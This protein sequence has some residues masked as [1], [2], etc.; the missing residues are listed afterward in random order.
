MQ[1]SM[2]PELATRRH[3]I[4]VLR[5]FAVLL[6][7]VFHTGM[8]FT[9]AYSF[10]IKNNDLSE[11]VRSL[12]DFIYTWH[13]PLFFFLAGMSAWY[14]LRRRTNRQFRVERLKRLFVPL[15]IGMAFIIPPQV[16]HAGIFPSDSSLVC[17]CFLGYL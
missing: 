11:A 15:L 1:S 8:V 3:E 7:I 10:H 4:D 16:S 5:V 2:L 13:M 6:L 17:I 12:I 9:A 14:A